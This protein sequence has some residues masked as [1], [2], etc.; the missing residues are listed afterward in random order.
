MQI[1][2]SHIEVKTPISEK[3]FNHWRKGEFEI[4]QFLLEEYPYGNH[5]SYEVKV[6]KIS[7]QQYRDATGW[8]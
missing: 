7:Q 1:E 3:A 2:F 8:W 5:S 4:P 6:N